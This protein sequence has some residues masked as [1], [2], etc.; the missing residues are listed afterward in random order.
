MKR[1]RQVQ[2]VFLSCLLVLSSAACTG[3]VG[4]DGSSD[5]N[6]PG[7]LYTT[8]ERVD[9]IDIPQI[10]EPDWEDAPRL[11]LE[12]ESWTHINM[13][14]KLQM[15]DDDLRAIQ[16]PAE[17]LRVRYLDL[18]HLNNAM[19]SAEQLTVYRQAL[20]HMMNSMSRG[21]RVAVPDAL[22]GTKT[23]L[24][25]KLDDF[26][27][28]T[29]TW[30]TMV[31][32]YP[33]AIRFNKDSQLFP[34]N[35]D[36]AERIR[37]DT[38]TDIPCVHVDWM[39]ANAARPPLYYEM[40]GAA[41]SVDELAAQLGV[42]IN[43]NIAN[44]QVAR[45]ATLDSGVAVN[46]RIV[47]RHSQGGVG[48][49]WIAYD[50]VDNIGQGNI[51]ANPLDFQPDGMQVMYTLPNGMLAFMMADGQGNRVGRAE[52]SLLR[53]PLADDLSVEV[54]V[55][56]MGGCH[57][58]DGVFSV[59]DVLRD[60]ALTGPVSADDRAR[61]A[62]LYPER[63]VFDGLVRTDRERFFDARERL[64]A[65]FDEPDTVRRTI[66]AFDAPLSLVRAATVM[67]ISEEEFAQALDAAPGSFAAPI[68]ALR[69]GALVPR[70]AFDAAYQQT[71]RAVGLGEPMRPGQN[72][73][74]EAP[75]E[76]ETPS[77]PDT[78]IDL[79]PSF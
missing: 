34:I 27:W 43:A 53:D 1:V 35:E 26:G 59:D 50:F 75:A 70:D 68:R 18:T 54:G 29:E 73:E 77:E 64:G 79:E 5:A 49:F 55:G 52:S 13:D 46:S 71:V 69:S 72:T 37:R 76:V 66:D 33:Y 65:A 38:G 30:S 44:G 2:R 19:Y 39:L 41:D 12:T 62:Q 48:S 45:A 32:N 22:D 24:R 11:L 16:N 60:Y 7:G 47:E 17:R 21:L 31:E 51:F 58:T 6:E 9:G 78:S 67:G 36:T 40:L 20:S 23:M 25:I 56:C 4:I 3:L 61:I 28:T 10:D 14:S 42:D 74:T 63:S 15:M 57:H 8:T